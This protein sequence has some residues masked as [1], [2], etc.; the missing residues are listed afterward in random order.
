MKFFKQTLC[1]ETFKNIYSILHA[2]F[3]TIDNFLVSDE[4]MEY[5]SRTSSTLSASASTIS[6]DVILQ[7]KTLTYLH[8]H[9]SYSFVSVS[10]QY[11]VWCLY[12]AFLS[13]LLNNVLRQNKTWL[14]KWNCNFLFSILFLHRPLYLPTDLRL[15]PHFIHFVYLNLTIYTFH[16]FLSILSSLMDHHHLQPL[17][18][19]VHWQRHRQ[20][21]LWW[22]RLLQAPC[23]V[24]CLEIPNCQTL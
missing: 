1:S 3:S 6:M 9:V 18:W 10:F 23:C 15:H 11:T 5:C 2:N 22:Q 17:S 20:P 14:I 19:L 4:M 16:F 13:Q 21:S 12:W 7:N 8:H 24:F